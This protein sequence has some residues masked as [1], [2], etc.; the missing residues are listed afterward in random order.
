M[1]SKKALPYSE[2]LKKIQ[3]VLSGDIAAIRHDASLPSRQVGRIDDA[4]G[5]IHQHIMEDKP[6]K[7]LSG[8]T[9]VDE[10][11]GIH[12]RLVV[13]STSVGLTL[14]VSIGSPANIFAAR[15][16]SLKMLEL[17][18]AVFSQYVKNLVSAGRP[19]AIDSLDALYA[20]VFEIDCFMH[21][22]HLTLPL[23]EEPE[24]LE[25]VECP[26]C[27]FDIETEMGELEKLARRQAR[28]QRRVRQE[29]GR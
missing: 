13:L 23:S 29:E 8:G 21:N 26:I 9:Y 15:E 10:M 16:A 25:V 27:S 3:E 28:E 17:I 1:P 4:L 7:S 6:F 18:T 24:E 2:A 20:S 22:L 11:L 19:A 14:D 5:D 12:S